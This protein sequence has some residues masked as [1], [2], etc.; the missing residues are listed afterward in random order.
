MKPTNED[1]PDDESEPS[2]FDTVSDVDV[3][4]RDR[5]RHLFEEFIVAPILIL[6][7]DWRALV[8]SLII[9]LYALIG[10]IGVRLIDEPDPTAGPRLQLPFQDMQ[11]PLGTDA[12]GQD[13]LA[14]TVH[15][16]PPMLKMILAGAVFSTVIATIV[17]T[18]SG[19]K[20]G[21]I[22]TVL[23][24]FTDVAMTLP[25]LP[26]IIVLAQIFP[27]DNPYAIGV[28]LAI[29]GWAGL[30]RALRSQVLTIRD[31]PYVE[32]SR[33]MDLSTSS[34]LAKD[35]LPN[36]MPYIAVNFVGTARS[37]IFSSVG[38]YF[39]GVLPFSDTNWGVMMNLA[40]ETGG[41]LYTWQ[42]AH[43]L[44]I[45]MLAVI[46]LSFGLI[47]FAQALDRIFNPRVRARHS[48]SEDGAQELR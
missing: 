39:I 44:L 46:I 7:D 48:G 13:L 47:L 10:T 29:N 23:M 18:L 45:P 5:Y 36:L 20:G 43:W 6:R 25:G 31:E 15:A 34:I 8:G 38:L 11:Y 27:I 42:S 1:V 4:A 14:Q 26:L 37:I 24:Y 41:S 12:L 35:I 33:T 40:Y 16:T 17:G 22:D 19:Y 28:L 30:A 9:V 21:A 32:A 2:P 3:T